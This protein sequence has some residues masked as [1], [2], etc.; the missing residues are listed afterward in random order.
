MKK[1][2][3]EEKENKNKQQKVVEDIERLRK[4]YKNAYMDSDD[5]LYEDYENLTEMEK[6]LIKSTADSAERILNEMPDCSSV[7]KNMDRKQQQV[8]G[9]REILDEISKV[10]Q[11]PLS[12]ESAE[13]FYYVLQSSKL[14]GLPTN[15]NLN[16]TITRTRKGIIS[17]LASAL[18]IAFTKTEDINE[19]ESLKD[20]ITI[21]MIKEDPVAISTIAFRISLKINKIKQQN[22][23]RANIPDS[24]DDMTEKLANGTLQIT[25]AKDTM[26]Q[27]SSVSAQYGNNKLSKSQI[28]KQYLIHIADSLM[29]SAD[30]YY[31][32]NPLLSMQK[33]QELTACDIEAALKIVVTNMLERNEFDRAKD[34]C[35]KVLET[36]SGRQAK[37]VVRDLEREIE[38]KK[39][40]TFI[41]GAISK[42]ENTEEEKEYF[43]YI[44]DRIDSG[45]I[46]P[47]TI[48]LG[49]NQSQTKSITLADV[50]EKNPTIEF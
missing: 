34:F 30:E 38:N 39:L 23:L 32:E 24:I 2:I 28:K 19:L 45:V 26:Q 49:K 7:E 40:G 46:K 11:Y 47:K 27:Q 20:K 1:S 4:K 21:G 16:S 12:V 29:K 50:W 48:V 15:T 25:E 31:I 6:K 37:K 14:Q 3:L 36:E 44:K 42:S 33:I 5:S 10:Q 18:Y 41:L 8:A 17:R 22:E 35:E 43:R 13:I 9:A